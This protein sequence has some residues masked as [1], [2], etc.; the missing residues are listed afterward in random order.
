MVV[1]A[2]QPVDFTVLNNNN[3]LPKALN[4]H[5]CLTGTGTLLAQHAS[6]WAGHAVH[7]PSTRA[8][9]AD[10]AMAHFAYT[11]TQQLSST[12]FKF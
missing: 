8:S 11:C 3:I 10:Q 6:A 7:W 1:E 4:A 5:A 2:N 9:R 12:F